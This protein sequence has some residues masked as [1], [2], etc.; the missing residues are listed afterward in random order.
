[1]VNLGVVL[2]GLDSRNYHFY[3]YLD[4][5]VS[6]TIL[7]GLLLVRRYN[8]ADREVRRSCLPIASAM[9]FII[10]VLQLLQLVFVQIKEAAELEMQEESKKHYVG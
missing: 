1:M 10:S 2:M 4:I 5:L 6:L 7:V 8:E 3:F 9:M